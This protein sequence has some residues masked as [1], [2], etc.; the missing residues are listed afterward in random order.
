MKLFPFNS[1]EIK[2]INNTRLLILTVYFELV[3][4]NGGIR[5]ASLISKIPISTLSRSIKELEETLGRSLFKLEK[6]TFSPTQEADRIY[7]GLDIN[8]VLLGVLSRYQTVL[9]SSSLKVQMNPYLKPYNCAKI[10]D[11][12]FHENKSIA[13]IDL[14]LK[15]YVSTPEKSLEK[16]RN[17]ELDICVSYTELDSFCIR[18]LLVGYDIFSVYSKSPIVNVDNVRILYVGHWENNALSNNLL[19]KLKDALSELNL[20]NNPFIEVSDPYTLM[21]ISERVPSVVIA[22][23]RFIKEFS[24]S[25]ENDTE[26]IPLVG[27]SLSYRLPIYLS[28]HKELHN[29]CLINWF[30]KISLSL[31]NTP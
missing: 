29:D 8:S 20:I 28:S 23:K 11:S 16:I 26:Y 18:N 10:L 19:F 9:S 27:D 21:N 2:S 15:A 5:E 3:Y 22:S 13:N 6:G 25:Y 24:N 4:R 14:E 1:S 7:L 17:G 31:Y 30:K 12:F